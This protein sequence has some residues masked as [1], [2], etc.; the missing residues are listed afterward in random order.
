MIGKGG[1]CFP[2]DVGSR[3]SGGGGEE[4]KGAEKVRR[5]GEGKRRRGENYRIK[6]GEGGGEGGEVVLGDAG[7]DFR[8][9]LIPAGEEEE[10]W[11]G[12]V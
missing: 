9:I 6:G 12:G 8:K 10:R 3:N 1:S 11:I 4:N 5:G 2:G 7:S